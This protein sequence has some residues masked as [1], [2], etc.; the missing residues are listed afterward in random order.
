MTGMEETNNSLERLHKTSIHHT[1]LPSGSPIY[2][3]KDLQ[4]DVGFITEQ[5]G[6]PIITTDVYNSP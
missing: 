2:Q 5:T 1:S 4:P 6:S 3:S